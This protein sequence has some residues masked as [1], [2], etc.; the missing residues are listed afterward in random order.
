M[1][2]ITATQHKSLSVHRE[3]S[4]RRGL[5]LW[6]SCQ[7]A[8]KALRINSTRSFLTMLGIMIGVAAVITA[9]MQTEGSSAS[10]RNTFAALGSNLLTVLPGAPPKLGKGFAISIGTKDASSTL[11]LGDVQALRG[12]AHV[13]A[14]GPLL[15]TG[16]KVIY[17]HNNGDFQIQGVSVDYPSIHSLRLVEGSWFSERDEEMGTPSIVIGDNAAQSL[18]LS[19]HVDPLTKTVRLG[20]QLF[21]VVGVLAPANFFYDQN[22]YAPYKTVQARLLNRNSVDQ[23]EVQVDGDSYLDLVQSEIVQLLET[24]HR[25]KQQDDFWVQSPQN[26]IMQSQASQSTLATLLIGIAAVSLTVGGIGIMN[27]MLVS[28]TERTREIGVRMAMGARK[29]DVRNQ[30]L[31]E[32]V[33]LSGLGGSIGVLLGIFIGYEV[34]LNSNLPFV[35][36]PIAILLSVSVASLTGIVFGFYPAV[37]A[38]D[39]DPI[40]ALR[41]S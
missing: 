37:R 25:N 3:W 17:Q 34:V 22:I 7:A 30:F 26:I 16:L 23:I 5:L 33:I 27:I 35:L 28:V 14:V 32:A 4:S 38:S 15:Q 40:V 31:I 2:S 6:A 41:N 9:T 39:L 10:I 24:R 19:Q 36:D 18:F 13:Q 21:H 12:L 29:S 11:T 8:I 20:G 1:K